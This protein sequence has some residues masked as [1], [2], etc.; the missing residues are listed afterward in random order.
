VMVIIGVS[1]VV[2]AVIQMVS[3]ALWR[4]RRPNPSGNAGARH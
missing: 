1:N 2:I 3:P 4:R